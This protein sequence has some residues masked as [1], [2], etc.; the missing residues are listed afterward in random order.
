MF[1]RVLLHL[2]LILPLAAQGTPPTLREAVG[3]ATADACA[4]D[5]EAEMKRTSP[6]TRAIG[7]SL[8]TVALV[9]AL[10]APASAERK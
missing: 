9:F 8:A 3:D 1:R 6:V 7:L 2:L 5:K 10:A 4:V